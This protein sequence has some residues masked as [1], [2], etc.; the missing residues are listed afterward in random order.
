MGVTA[1]GKEAGVG[2]HEEMLFGAI[3]GGPSDLAFWLRFGGGQTLHSYG[4]DSW[5][6]I[7]HEHL[8]FLGACPLYHETPTHI[9]VHANLWPNRRMDEQPRNALLWEP[10]QPDQPP[11]HYSGK[12]IVV[13][14]TPQQS[15]QVLVLGSAKCIDTGCGLGGLLT[16]LD[17]RSD[18]I[19]QVN[20][21]GE[22]TDH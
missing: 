8:D 9:F 16:A 13:G 5:H 19:W 21:Q 4:S 22:R 3:Q 20:E 17:V 10:L 2:N 1:N 18:R 11:R 7:P 12:T 14:H 6:A 15:G